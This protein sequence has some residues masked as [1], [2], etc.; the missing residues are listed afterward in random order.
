ML[1]KKRITLVYTLIVTIILLVL[2]ACI[3][4]FSYTSRVE[5]FKLRLK[6]KA[7]ST[8]TLIKSNEIGPDIVKEMNRVSSSGLSYK[9]VD[10]YDFSYN[11]TFSYNDNK[12]DTLVVTDDI[13][14]RAKIDKIFFFKAGYREAIAMEYK[15]AGY[16]YI[17]VVAA[18][19][20]ERVEWLSRLRVI[21][22]ICFVFSISIVIISGYVFSVGLLKPINELT[23]K[24]NHISSEDLSKRLDTGNGRNELQ[25]LAATINELLNRLQLSFDTQR[26]FIDNA[27]HELSTPLASIASQLDVALQR[28]RSN[29]DYRNV[30]GSVNDDLKNLNMLVKSLLEIAKVSGSPKGI[31]LSSVRVD[32]IL[33]HLPGDM[34]KINRE[35]AVKLLFDEFPENEE[36]VMVYG[37]EYLLYSAI[38]NIVHNACKFSG[39]H[40]AIV[41]LMF[42]ADNII[43][44]IEDKGPGISKSEYE[45]IFQPFYRS[46]TLLNKVPGSGLGLPL[47]DHIVKLYN[48]TIEVCS[49]PGQGSIF[50]ITLKAKK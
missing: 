17:I 39:D 6:R 21:L 29:E 41:K 18:Y 13:L 35:Y 14:Q 10:L 43:V 8:A 16:N 38:K 45:N 4:I 5:Q 28:E 34:K 26:R 36:A 31:E 11:E 7:L 44:E 40:T 20:D 37:N 12:N 19:D 27:S 23:D 46:K 48:G 1:I 50:T 3:Y 22:A 15:E 2:C 47:A 25:Q 49:Q 24:I 30:L 32:E 9:S 42:N 33:L